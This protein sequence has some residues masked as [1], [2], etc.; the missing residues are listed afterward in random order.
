L[1]TYPFR[2]ERENGTR[3]RVDDDG[4]VT[5]KGARDVDLSRLLE[6]LVTEGFQSRG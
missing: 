6:T 2:E 4:F 3:G 5:L 1:L